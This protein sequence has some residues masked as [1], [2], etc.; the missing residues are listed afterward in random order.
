MALPHRQL[1]AHRCVHV[2]FFSELCVAYMCASF[3]PS[4]APESAPR[5]LVDCAKTQSASMSEAP[6]GAGLGPGLLAFLNVHDLGQKPTSEAHSRGNSRVRW[7]MLTCVCNHGPAPELAQHE[8][9]DC[10]ESQPGSLCEHL[11]AQGLLSNS[12]A[13]LTS[14]EEPAVRIQEVQWWTLACACHQMES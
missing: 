2:L 7:R 1:C 11:Q 3:T 12:F 5:I 8:V 9:L 13:M 10:L 4:L 6:S 14:Q